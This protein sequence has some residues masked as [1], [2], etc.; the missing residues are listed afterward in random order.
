MSE[1]ASKPSSPSSGKRKIYPKSDGWYELKSD[2]TETKIAGATTLN[3]LTDVTILSTPTKGQVLIYDADDS[4]T[5]V[6][7]QTNGFVFGCSFTEASRAD[8][9]STNSTSYVNYL[10]EVAGTCES[11]K[12]YRVGVFVT[13]NGSSTG[14]DSYAEVTIQEGTG[15]PVQAGELRVEPKEAGTDNEVPHSGFFYYTPTTSDTI[16]LR[17]NF[18][19]ENSDASAYMFYAGLEWWRAEL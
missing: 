6:P 1:N 13:M 17:I 3:D 7:A 10:T 4:G 2:G 15:T 19:S 18:K 5:W 16:T 8:F 12:R 9:T 14:R 11:N